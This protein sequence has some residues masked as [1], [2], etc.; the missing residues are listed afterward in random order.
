MVRSGRVS[1]RLRGVSGGL[2]SI[3][4]LVGCRRDTAS[5]SGPDASAVTEQARGPAGA[6]ARAGGGAGGGA[7]AV[8]DP[9]NP[10]MLIR[11]VGVRRLVIDATHIYWMDGA[12][13]VWRVAKTGGQ[14]QQLAVAPEAGTDRRSWHPSLLVLRDDDLVFGNGRSI[15]SVPKSGGATATIATTASHPSWLGAS[16]GDLFWEAGDTFFGWSGSKEPK[17]LGSAKDVAPYLMALDDHH[18]YFHQLGQSGGFK[19]ISRIPRGGG[20]IADFGRS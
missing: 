9:D 2:L 14:A 17:S 5:T 10:Y 15:V 7:A 13:N 12:A 6:V 20:S 16:G 1:A 18:L 11:S 8:K 19:G 4:V 3:A